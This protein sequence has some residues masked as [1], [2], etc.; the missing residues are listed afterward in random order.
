MTDHPPC[1]FADSWKAGAEASQFED[2]QP[3]AEPGMTFAALPWSGLHYEY[4]LARDI[5][6]KPRDQAR[7]APDVR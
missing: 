2:G 3:P 5:I 6:K 1:P 7:L 4:E